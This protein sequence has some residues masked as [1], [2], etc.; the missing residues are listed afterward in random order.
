MDGAGKRDLSLSALLVYAL[1]GVAGIGTLAGSVAFLSTGGGGLFVGVVLFVGGAGTVAWAVGKT[2]TSGDLSLLRGLGR[3]SKR[4]ERLGQ[5]LPDVPPASETDERWSTPQKVVSVSMV[6]VLVLLTL[7]TNAVAADGDSVPE[8]RELIGGTDPLSADTD[9]DG[10]QDGRERDEGA[11]P[12]DPDSDGDGLDD[13]V[14]VEFGSDPLDAD[15][16]DDGVADVGEY[17]RGTDPTSPDTDEDGLED[18]R[19]FDLGTDP[20]DADTDG[21]GHQDGREV[22]TGADPLVADQDQDGLSDQRERELGTDVDEADSDDDGLED[23][24]EVE[25]GTDPLEEDS[26]GDLLLDGW[27]VS[28]RRDGP[29]SSDDESLLTLD[30]DDD[31]G[32]DELY[33]DADPLTKDIY[34]NVRYGA[35]SDPLSPAEKE[36]V[37]DAF[38]GI[39]IDNPSGERGIRVHITDDGSEAG[40][41]SRSFDIEDRED[42]DDLLRSVSTLGDN[43]AKAV[44]YTAYLVSFD[45]SAEFAG[46]G[47]APGFFSVVDEGETSRYGGTIT[48]RSHAMIHELLHNVVGELDPGNRAPGEVGHSERGWLSYPDD[49]AQNEYLPASI[50]AEIERDGFVSDQPRFEESRWRARSG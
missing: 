1:S 25:V 5:S 2:V 26:D 46:T 41:M 4:L 11:D 9:S 45:R 3:T 23:G 42:V 37:R 28:A 31:G 20:T 15:T 48:Y 7:G 38:A 44:S 18:E 10:L 27:E 49:L 22:D 13:G 12:T 50:A 34:L 6:A 17:R 36:A 24:R 30:D 14:E 29:D 21:D 43:G 33:P 8:I 35:D 39:P 32:S 47:A 16:D 19:E 40:M